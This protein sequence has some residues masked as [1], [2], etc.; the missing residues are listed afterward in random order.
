MSEIL[1]ALTAISPA[2][3]PLIGVFIGA[4]L[5]SRAT[6]RSS[7]NALTG[8]RL[9]M[10]LQAEIKLSDFR[11][12]W[13]NILRDC[14]AELQSI[15]MTPGKEAQKEQRFYELGTKV[16][17][18]INNKDEDYE[19][20]QKIMYRLLFSETIED[21]YRCNA[22]FVEVGQRIL[23]REWEVL[24]VSLRAAAVQTP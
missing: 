6:L 7:R 1:P 9:Q 19:P 15:G 14:L 23:K 3:L 10:T 4:W 17:L 20:L 11:Q 18:L 5:T 16:E 24:K 13:I 12:A 21:K 22:E 2:V 8:I